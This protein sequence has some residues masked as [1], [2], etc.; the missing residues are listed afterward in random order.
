MMKIFKKKA[1]YIDLIL[2]ISSVL[3]VYSIFHIG[4]LGIKYILPIILIIF[5]I[6]ILLIVFANKK[7]KFKDKKNLS[8]KKL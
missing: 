6:D 1:F 7:Y 5:I 3:L 2:V 4:I 8:K